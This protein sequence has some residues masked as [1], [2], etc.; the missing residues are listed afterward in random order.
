MHNS[1]LIVILYSGE[2][3]LYLESPMETSLSILRTFSCLHDYRYGPLVSVR[4]QT[5]YYFIYKIKGNIGITLS[6]QIVHTLFKIDLAIY[7]ASVM[8]LYGWK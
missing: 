5:I 2:S 8:V 1:N 4:F 7:S 3:F 6:H